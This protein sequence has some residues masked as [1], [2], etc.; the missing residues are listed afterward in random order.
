MQ[1][2]R[3]WHRCNSHYNRRMALRVASHLMF[4]GTA[5]AAIDLYAAT[6]PSFRVEAIERYDAPAN[7]AP[8]LIKRADVSFAGH[9]LII[10]DSPV[11]H[12]FTF[13]PAMSLFVECD[14]HEELERAFATL[15]NGG[16]VYMPLDS[17]GFSARFGWCSDRFG[18]SW[19][20]NLT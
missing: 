1:K 5:S 16:Q 4:T 11:T 13:T 7:G 17:Y 9:S 19:Q 20:L 18:V 3:A 2:L 14:S 15:S 12:A 6:F 8:A 10:I